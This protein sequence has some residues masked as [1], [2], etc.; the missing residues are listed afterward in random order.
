[1]AEWTDGC[2]CV[3]DVLILHF[4]MGCILQEGLYRS[5]GKQLNELYVCMYGVSV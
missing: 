4:S 5:S 2:T 1:M 3:Y